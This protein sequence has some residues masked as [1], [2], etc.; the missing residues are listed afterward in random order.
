MKD[1]E[2]FSYPEYYK[3]IKY[4]CRKCEFYQDK[5]LLKRVIRIC[6]KKGLRNVPIQKNQ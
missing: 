2:I 3:N 1:L 6:K 4:Y 5:C